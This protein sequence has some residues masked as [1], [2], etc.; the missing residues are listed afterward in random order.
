G[1]ITFRENSLLLDPQRPSEQVRR[2]IAWT[3]AHEIAH[4]WFGN[5]VTM[6]WWD[7]LWLSEAFA[8]W[9]STKVVDEWHPEYRL[10][11]DFEESRTKAMRGDALSS[12]RQ[13]RQPVRNA[14]DAAEAF[15]SITYDKGQALI[16]MLE[17][18]LGGDVF[19]AA[20]RKHLA[21]HAWRTAS[22]QALLD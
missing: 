3:M 20:L 21:R 17:G 6:A 18:W 8:S 10:P 4:Q 5:W 13:I 14:A 7:D 2:N 9:V 19:R 22:T 15:D 1:L 11:L 12:A 16:T